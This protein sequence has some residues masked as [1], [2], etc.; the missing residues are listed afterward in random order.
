MAI[1]P[2]IPAIDKI[3]KIP[4]IDKIHNIPKLSKEKL[5]EQQAKLSKFMRLF[6]RISEVLGWKTLLITTIFVVIS[7]IFLIMLN[8]TKLFVFI[9]FLYSLY[10][11][12]Q[13]SVFVYDSI[14]LLLDDN[15][16]SVKKLL[17]AY[18]ISIVGLILL[19]ALAYEVVLMTNTGY[20][21]YSQCSDNFNPESINPNSNIYDS[22][23][24]FSHF[25]AF[26]FSAITFFSVGYGDICPMGASR[27][28]SI[29][30]TWLGHAYTVIILGMA[31]AIYFKDK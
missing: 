17:S 9:I 24:V 23:I 6:L 7:S 29:I 15:K 22:K 4:H 8:A 12:L 18:F 11:I 27:F 20:L 25:G 30:N 10:L 14:K 1:I 2:K 3:P 19:F 16:K 13:T 21:T 5:L 26:Y 31:L 28:I